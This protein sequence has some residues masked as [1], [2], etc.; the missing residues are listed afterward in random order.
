M[1]LLLFGVLA[2]LTTGALQPLGRVGTLRRATEELAAA[3]REGQSRALGS[4]SE[5]E[6]H[7]GETGW[8]LVTW[9]RLGGALSIRDTSFPVGVTGPAENEQNTRIRFFPAGTVSPRT[10]FLRSGGHTGRITVSLRGRVTVYI[11]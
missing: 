6:L 2:A 9:N 8:R 5:Y 10:L 4:D 7:V 11:E 3:L 1:S